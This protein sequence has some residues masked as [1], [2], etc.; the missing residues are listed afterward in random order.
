MRLPT[1]PI[2]ALTL[3]AFVAVLSADEVEEQ[4]KAI[5]A[6]YDATENANLTELT[7][8]LDEGSGPT[9]LVRYSRDGELVKLVYRTGGDHGVSDESFFFDEGRLYFVFQSQQFWSFDPAAGEGATI[10]TGRERRLYLHEGQVIRHLLK[11]VKSSDAD[12]IPRLLAK[13]RNVPVDD[14]DIAGRLRSAADRLFAIES[15]AQLEKFLYEE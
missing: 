1:F 9:K 8:D 12:A 7:I 4:V 15:K 2:F 3:L 6:A 5:R 14:A 10:D 13:A 11:E